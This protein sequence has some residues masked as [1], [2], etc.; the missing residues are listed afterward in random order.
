V[1]VQKLM[2]GQRLSKEKPLRAFVF[3]EVV[4]EEE[5]DGSS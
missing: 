5:D 4:A 2:I 3:L 1:K